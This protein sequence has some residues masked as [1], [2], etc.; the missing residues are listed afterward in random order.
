MQS[1]DAIHDMPNG[2]SALRDDYDAILVDI[3][4]Y[5]YEYDITSTE[6]WKRARIAL[7]DAL[8]CA[9]ETLHTSP[10]CVSLLGPIVPGTDTPNGFRLPG[11]AHQLD[12]IKGAF[13]L[14]SLIRYLDH[15]D[16]YP[17]AEWGHPSDNLGALLSVADWLSRSTNKDATASPSGKEAVVT[18]LQSAMTLKTLLTAQI[19]A[20][21]IQGVL[22]EKNSFNAVGLDHTILVKIA[23]T[24][25]VSWLLGLS[26]PQCLAALSQAFQDGHPIRTYRQA[27]NAGPRK[28]WAAGDA[29][30]R[31]VLMALVTQKGQPGAPSVLT[32]ERWGFYQTLFHGK[33]FIRQREFGSWVMESVAFKLFPVEG[34]AISACEAAIK[35]AKRLKEKK[36]G[37]VEEIEKVIIRTQKPAFTIVN[38]TGVLRN[39][40]DRDHCIQYIIAVILLKGDAIDTVDYMDHSSWASDPRVD[41]LR[42]KMEVVEDVRF[43]EDYLNPRKRSCANGI[44]AFLKGGQEIEEVVEYP[45]GHPIRTETLAQVAVKVRRNLGL[46]FGEE[47]VDEILKAVERDDLPVK[48][49]VDLF[50]KG[51]I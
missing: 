35:L 17:G 47:K 12:P 9:I 15:N 8:S 22:Q 21:E 6:A 28:G 48:D 51:E 32:A 49:F 25:C 5:V 18:T 50:W 19:K 14:G 20:Y 1:V 41:A 46:G 36:A 37:V 7:L 24:A 43:S 30:L 27:P 13:D 31:A 10:E 33:E 39:A 34:H 3:T 40:A 44:K 42:E 23:S 4:K 29:C 38:K 11:T 26:Q 45:L 16:A 2:G